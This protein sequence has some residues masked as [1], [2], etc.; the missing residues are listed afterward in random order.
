MAAEPDPYIVL[1]LARGA[2]LDEVKRAYRRLAKA[3]HPDAVGE[4]NVARFLAIQA[5]YERLA[6]RLDPTGSGSATARPMPPRRPWEADPDRSE[7]TRR[8][9]GSRGRPAGRAGAPGRSQTSG[10]QDVGGTSNAGSAT[11]GPKPGAEDA[12]QSKATP[13]STSYDGADATPFEPDWGGA[14][15]YGTTSGTYWT[16]N[17]KEYADPRKHGP[18]Y[19][20][21]ARRAARGGSSERSRIGPDPADERDDAG[22]TTSSWWESTTGA[23]AEMGEA[24]E[25]RPPVDDAPYQRGVESAPDVGRALS[26]VGRILSDERWGGVR[27]R[28]GRGLIGWLPIALGIG[29]LVGEATGCSRFAATCDGSAGPLTLVLQLAALALLI[30]VPLLGSIATMAAVTLLGVALVA[31]VILSAN[32]GQ[33][34]DARRTTLGLILIV[35]WLVGA[36][37]AVA[38]RTRPGAGPA[39]PVS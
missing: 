14:S 19:Q 26:D 16:L 30:A 32:G 5:A 35:G 13:G 1:G 39:R 22:H 8:A 12:A 7:S 9:Y 10:P 37:I 2:S 6:V 4:R 36:A 17:P 15:W 3:N 34:D 29:W 11:G 38:Q 25:V 18:E 23:G 27:G 31:A 20:A 33:P 24:A 21:R 28:L